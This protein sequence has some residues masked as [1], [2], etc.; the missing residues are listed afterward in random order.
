[1]YGK[2]LKLKLVGIIMKL[3][4]SIITPTYNLEKYISKCIESALAQTFKD[5]EMIIVND[6]SSDKT[7]LMLSQAR[8]YHK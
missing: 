4:I 3:V 5:W 2:I 6:G 1:M 7:L 8:G